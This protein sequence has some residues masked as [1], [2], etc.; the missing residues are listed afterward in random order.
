[1]SKQK[2]I[3]NNPLAAYLS[4]EPS[5]EKSESNSESVTEQFTS[6]QNRVSKK[7]RI[8]IHVSSEIIERVK[9]AVFW[10]PGLTL[11]GFTEHALEKAITDFEAERGSAFPQRRH[12]LRG[13]RPLK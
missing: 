7:Q 6:E 12:P 2:T 11:A 10:E 8:T 3:G 9:N 1:M 13:G 5:F 4:A